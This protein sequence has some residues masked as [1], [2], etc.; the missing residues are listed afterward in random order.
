MNTTEF[1]SKRDLL[2]HHFKEL[3]E[4]ENRLNKMR[5]DNLIFLMI[6]LEQDN[7]V[8]KL[9][10]KGMPD[11]IILHPDFPPEIISFFKSICSVVANQYLPPNTCV[12]SWQNNRMDLSVERGI[13]SPTV[14]FK[15]KS[16]LRL[17]SNIFF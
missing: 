12:F 5:L 13:Y 2:L 9:Q 1:K 11:V 16:C 7:S 6:S 4:K 17:N 8:K 10:E 14:L 3:S 15:D